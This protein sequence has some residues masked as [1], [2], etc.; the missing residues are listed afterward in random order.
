[1]S[2]HRPRCCG[3]RNI[4]S[5][6]E[7]VWLSSSDGI[8]MQIKKRAHLPRKASSLLVGLDKIEMPDF[9]CTRVFGKSL[10]PS[11]L[12]GTTERLFDRNSCFTR[13]RDE[14]RKVN[15][16]MWCKNGEG[17]I[18]S[19]LAIPEKR[20]IRCNS[21]RDRCLVSAATRIPE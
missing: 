13:F 16:E 17:E 11:R 18:F 5:K 14:I 12:L 20:R 7:Y 10:D 9:E 3:L 21:V 6:S 19:I 8:I 1:M 4:L 15:G 2:F